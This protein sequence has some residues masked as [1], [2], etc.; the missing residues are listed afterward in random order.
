MRWRAVRWGRS[1]LEGPGLALV[2]ALALALAVPAGACR[3]SAAAVAD[4][5]DALAALAAP[6]QSARYDGPFWAREAH[7]GSRTWRAARAF[8][9]G[10]REAPELPNCHPVALVE[11]WEAPAAREM[12]AGLPPLAAPPPLPPALH[13]GTAGAARG[14]LAAVAAWEARLLARGRAAAGEGR[15]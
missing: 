1:E 13:P 8:C 10:R 7:R 3:P 2:V 5:D 12:P 6:V 11:R 9:A 15:R 4:G 14:D